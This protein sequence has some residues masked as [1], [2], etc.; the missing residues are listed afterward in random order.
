MNQERKEK[1]EALAHNVRV[2]IIEAGYGAGKKGGHFGGSLS[3]A[4]IFSVLYDGYV[5]YKMDDLENRDRVILSKG[6]AAL[7][8]YAILCEKC[9]ITR[10]DLMSFEHNA[11]NF[12][13]HSKRFI[14][15][16]LEFAGGSLS[17]GLAYGVGVAYACKLKDLS[18]RVYVIVGDGEIN[19]G[20]V[21]ETMLF[22]A[23]K[24]LYNLTIIVDHNHL[25]ADG[26]IEDVINTSP[27]KLKFE[28]FGFS[29][30]EVD[31]HS[32]EEL[33]NAFSTLSNNKPTAIIAETVKGKG[34][35]FMEDKFK[36]HHG[37]L[38]DSKYKKAMKELGITIE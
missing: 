13:A 21:W 20:L 24:N 11:S 27:L 29:T 31:G 38:T 34:I 25:Q 15:K 19:E 22:A 12:V 10:E 35:S 28:S 30:V 32:V 17:L 26:Y 23:H 9:F 7:G 36:W 6:H 37:T 1:F 8:H 2:N 33:D 18:N 3:M 16:G 5:T 14:D 4:E